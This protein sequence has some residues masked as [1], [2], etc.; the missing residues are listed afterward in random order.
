MKR[1]RLSRSASK[2][3]FTRGAMRTNKRN[4]NTSSPMRG[5]IRL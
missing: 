5:G 4:L 2:R 3:S 1:M